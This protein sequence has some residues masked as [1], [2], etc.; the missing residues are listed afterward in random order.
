VANGGDGV[1]IDNALNNTI[2]GARDGEGNEI[3]HNGGAGIGVAS[4]R[5]N[6]FV[7]N[8]VHDNAGLGIDLNLDGVTENDEGDGDAGA[9]RSQNFPE[10]DRATTDGEKT[11]VFTQLRD[12]A[13][14]DNFYVDYY[15]TPVCDGSG[16][17][18][19]PRFLGS[20]HHDARGPTDDT[21]EAAVD[22]VPPG[23]SVTATATRTDH[24]APPNAKRIESSELSRCEVALTRPPRFWSR[25]IARSRCGSTSRCP[26]PPLIR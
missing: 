19:A 23:W 6:V 18:E 24:Y 11:Y 26:I 2:G 21:F 20:F 10:L 22:P 12:P 9:N 1:R 14:W 13:I 17:G 25:R 8:L 5:G 7:R 3:A 16:H 15:A 4:L